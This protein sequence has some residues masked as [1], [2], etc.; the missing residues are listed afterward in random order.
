MACADAHISKH[1]KQELAWAA[2]KHLWVI[3]NM[4]LDLGRCTQPT[5]L[6]VLIWISLKP[7]G[8]VY[9]LQTFKDDKGIV[10]LQS[11]KIS[12]VSIIPN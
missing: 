5:H 2:D 9:R 11:L 3:S 1:S 6:I 7:Q 8:M 12:H 4:R 10:V